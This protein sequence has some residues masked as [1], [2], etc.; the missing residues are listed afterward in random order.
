MRNADKTTEWHGLWGGRILRFEALESTNTWALAHLAELAQGDVVWAL[1]QTAGR[2]RFDRAWIA[3]PGK[4]LTVS[5]ILIGAQWVALAPNVGQAAAW[6]VQRT[7]AAF[8]VSARLKWPNDV[9]VGNHKIAGILVER[10]A[11]A[12][13][14]VLGIG[15]NVNLAAADLRLA[16]LDRMATSMSMAARRRFRVEAVLARLLG[17]LQGTL[18]TV[19]RDGLA[20]VLN[21]WALSD[22]LAGHEVEIQGAEATLRGRYE[23]LDAAGRLRLTGADGTEHLLWTGDVAR[24]RSVR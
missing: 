3:S 14:F 6:G 24:V 18:D 12:N 16:A 20:P 7:L 2:G 10:G 19:C 1:D 8:D 15:L 5:T 17:E 13:A 22:W 23:G 4:C 9:M 21:A 11:A